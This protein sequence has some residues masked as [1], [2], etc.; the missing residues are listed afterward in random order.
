MEGESVTP[1][2]GQGDTGPSAGASESPS[3]V[4]P[5]DEALLTGKVETSEPEGQQ[6]PE[7]QQ[8]E[9]GKE[10]VF[11]FKM[12]EGF[13]LDP[14]VQGRFVGL[15]KDAKISPENGQKLLELAVDHVQR[16]QN[17]GFAT[18]RKQQEDWKESLR[19]DKDFGGQ[20]YPETLKA[21][22]SI[23]AKFGSPELVNDLT[24][25]GFANNAELVK[26]LARVRKAIGEDRVV[27]GGPAG[28]KS[29][30]KAEA[31]YPTMRQR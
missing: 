1:N 16:F 15:L 18:W 25:T 3:P 4:V 22:N 7:E 30:S 28:A 2:A 6:K 14:E 31:M 29:M 9:P 13:T 12:P 10:E 24:G 19:T 21:A 26:L 20:K 8:K 17:E 5:Q 11:E 23:L 27:E